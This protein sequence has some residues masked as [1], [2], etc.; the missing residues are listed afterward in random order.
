MVMITVRVDDDIKREMERAKHVN[1]SEVIRKAIID[2]LKAEGGSNLA[3]AVLLNERNLVKPDE[4][5]N[6]VSVIRQW[7]EAIRWDPREASEQS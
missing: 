7:R 2:V 1:W 4:G 5:F 3:K 6:S